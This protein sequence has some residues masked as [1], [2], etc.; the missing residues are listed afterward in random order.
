M[1]LAPLGSGRRSRHAVFAL[2][3]VAIAGL[4]GCAGRPGPETLD[5]VALGDFRPERVETLYTVTTR[6][7]LQAGGNAFSYEKAREPNYA[8]FEISIP[9]THV[10]SNIEWPKPGRKPDPKTDF[11]VL[12]QNDLGRA[13]LLQVVRQSGP[14]APVVFVHGYN[15]NFQESLYR[16]AQL[17]TDSNIGGTPILFAWPSHAALA[18][19][20]ADK[21]SATYSRDAL[22][23]LLIDLVETRRGEVHVFA[24][25]MGGWLTVEV[26]RQLKLEGRDD[27][28]SRL[29]VIMAAPDID[30]D[31]FRAQLDVI[32][33]MRTPIT[34]L[35]APDDRALQVSS[36]LGAGTQRVGAIDARN[37]QV[38]EAAKRYGITIIDISSLES[39]DATN[40]NRAFDARQL[41][42]ALN[43]PAA[44]A[45]LGDAG[46]FVLDAAAQT[47]SSPFSLAATVLRQR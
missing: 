45:T 22:A 28:L 31:V 8:R 10:S 11:A 20:V 5:P 17:K 35:V 3:L 33:R 44:T 15:Y 21:E 6:D 38:A 23:K 29:R 1:M 32:G 25:S 47:V 7:R 2:C 14:A 18:A 37:P 4:S 12:A 46:A 13:A 27:V 9:P 36:F 43:K 41:A 16:L 26:L 30:E 40:H 42:E 34:I 24:H 19:Y 39:I